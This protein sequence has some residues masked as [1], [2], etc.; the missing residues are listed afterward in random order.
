MNT[1]I[2]FDPGKLKG[3]PAEFR[4]KLKTLK[5]NPKI[6]LIVTGIVSSIWFLVR[7]IPKPSRAA[8]PCMKVAAPL[9]S[10]FVLYLLSVFGI[11]IAAR[12]TGYR[13]INSRYIATFLLVTGVV[14]LMAV[15][16]SQNTGAIQKKEPVK[17]GPDDGPNKPMGKETGIYPGRVVWIWDPKATNESCT[18]SFEL[19]R[20]ENTNQGVVNRMVVDGIKKLGGKSNL[21]EAWNDIF[22]SFNKKKHNSDKGYTQGEKIFI[23]IN[24]GTANARLRPNDIENGF[25]IPSRMTESEQAKK[26]L[27][28]TCETYPN[29]TLEIL[30]ELINVMGI[31]QKN[32][33]IGDP[34][35]HIFG[36]NYEA[37]ATEFPDV[38]YVD[39]ASEKHGR[40]LIRPTKTDLIFYSDKSQ[41]D[42]LYDIIESA[43]Y[44]INIANLK[45]HGRAGISLTAKN[46]FGSQARP[47]AAHLHHSLIAPVS[48]GN[49]S[50]SGYGKYRVLVDLMGSRYLGGNTLLFVVDGL[51]GG[52]S[53]ETKVPVKYFMPPFNNDW[54]NSIFMS[55]DQVALESVCYDF[56]RSEWNGMYK[57]NDA[58]NDYESIPGVNGVDDYLHQAA[59][60]SAWPKNISYDPDKSGKPLGS[61]GIHEHWN[62]PVRKQYSR[63]LGLSYG[64]E[65]IAVP[66]TLVR[67]LKQAASAVSA[68]KGSVNTRTFDS[69]FTAKNFHSVVVDDED[70]K[71]FLTDAG[72]ASFNGNKWQLHNRNRKVPAK[73]LEDM[74]FD[75]S[76]YGKELWLASPFGATVVTLP[77]DARSGATTYY[78]GNSKILSDTV[79][80]VAVGKG[81]LRW[82]GT[83]KGVSAFLDNKWLTY[84]YQRQYPESLFQDFPITAM[85]TTPGG[86][87]L[88]VATKG[89]G[90]AR[91]F[92]DKVDAISGASEYAIWGPIEMPSDNVY[93][94]C[95]TPD[96]TQWYGTDMGIARHKGS[97]TLENW[98]IF[99]TENGLVDNFVQCIAYD[100]EGSLWFGTK[101]GISV[102]KGEEWKSFTTEN[103]LISNNIQ[104]IT[105]DK[106]G[107]IWCGTENGVI[108][109]KNG[110][111][112]N[113]K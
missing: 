70:V 107:V 24:Q 56:L 27:A 34:I 81:A 105:V 47:S 16:P 41:S 98:T 94:I 66:D 74:A 11:T 82:F 77:V 55:Q 22:R 67:S 44:L 35:S 14:V 18:N 8:Y 50:N 96:G 2:K 109:F 40:T 5:L 86:D 92:R 84:S 49:T 58:N 1:R 46:H 45:P 48:L 25:Y 97:Q 65:L 39:R 99:T 30:R 57:H 79:V 37:W 26:G 104:C 87:S 101:G 59:D 62:D 111:I 52:G 64:I 31:E 61:L 60:P 4:D 51:Y 23:K 90:V 110:S 43:D 29:V 32:I 103:G 6:V 88:Y 7:V 54:S 106:E 80:A 53:N 69:G 13:I 12:K 17:T 71:W 42:K 113:Y 63:N 108:S 112:T 76:S 28:G 36:H 75:I 73:G 68:G 19:C 38:V 78:K 10:G 72:I 89:A 91:V 100:N 85:A 83:N 9:M 102:L 93:S 95:I 20:P 21:Y 3:K 33:A 15:T